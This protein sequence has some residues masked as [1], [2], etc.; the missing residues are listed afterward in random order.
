MTD[1]GNGI[2]V[3]VLKN[4]VCIGCGVCSAACPSASLPML[5]REV[6]LIPPENAREKFKRMLS[7]KG[8]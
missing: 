4:E 8:R 5:R 7:E 2:E 1:Q 3:P 6:L